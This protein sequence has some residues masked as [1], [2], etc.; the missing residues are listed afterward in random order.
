MPA[1]FWAVSS[2]VLASS[3]PAQ[4]WRKP[5]IWC[6]WRLTPARTTP[7]ITAL[8]PGQ[9]PPPV[10][11][12]KRAIGPASCQTRAVRQTRFDT[13]GAPCRFSGA[14]QAQHDAL[15]GRQ[16]QRPRHDLAVALAPGADR[17][18]ALDRDARRARAEVERDQ[19]ALAAPVGPQTVRDRDLLV[20]ARAQVLLRAPQ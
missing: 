4:P 9:S 14:R 3:T 5:M 6:P 16:Q 19:E 15:A 18:R 2:T 12:P 7:R 17:D 8:R 20:A 13:R 11:M 10:R 1:V